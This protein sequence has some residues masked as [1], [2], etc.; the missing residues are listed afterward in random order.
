ME[1]N[2]ATSYVPYII[3]NTAV[4]GCEMVKDFWGGP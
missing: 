3:V 2:S 4:L 1:E